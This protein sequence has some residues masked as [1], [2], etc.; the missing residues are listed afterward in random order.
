MIPFLKPPKCYGVYYPATE[1][2]PAEGDCLAPS[3][4][5]NLEC[6][7]CLA[8]FTT[9]GGTIHPETGKKIPYLLARL[10][11][12]RPDFHIP[13]E[14]ELQKERIE[15]FLDAYKKRRNK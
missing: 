5:E 8:A 1:L 2:G 15:R 6:D 11:Y 7:T 3:G 13:T 14:E 12:G 9:N 10:L 4:N